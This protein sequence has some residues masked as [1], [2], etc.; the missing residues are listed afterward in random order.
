MVEA[1]DTTTAALRCSLR[2]VGWPFGGDVLQLIKLDEGRLSLT[3]EMRADQPSPAALGWHPW[4]RRSKGDERIL[5][6]AVETLE[7]TPDLI[8]SGKT[9]PVDPATD[10][11]SG[12]AIGTRAL[13]HTYVN[14][15]SPILLRTEGVDITVWFERPICAVVVHTRRDA[16]CVEPQTS[17]P[18]AA[19]LEVS[20]IGGTGLRGLPAGEALTATCVWSWQGTDA[21]EPGK[22]S[23]GHAPR[24]R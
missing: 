8:P 7:T 12:P 1:Q 20:G 11:R 14:P 15:A 6:N 2:D 9:I 4:F 16:F 5:V 10:L 24:R 22:P 17:W 19:A 21:T 23:M 3:G 13:D 18:N